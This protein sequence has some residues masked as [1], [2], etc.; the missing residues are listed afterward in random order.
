V[1][2]GL[3]NA[4]LEG[5]QRGT[6]TQAA[7]HGPQHAAVPSTP[8]SPARRGPQHASSRPACFL[9]P[10][11]DPDPLPSFRSGATLTPRGFSLPVFLSYSKVVRQAASAPGTAGLLPRLGRLFLSAGSES[12]VAS[13]LG[14]NRALTL[15]LLPRP[16]ACRRRV[17]LPHPHVTAHARLLP[18]HSGPFPTACTGALG[19]IPASG[20][21]LK[22]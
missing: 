11:Q 4:R 9:S 15:S 10:W 1:T 8:R 6:P 20:N 14:E 18:L 5:E 19:Q 17:T 21:A 22:C 13:E 2:G 16:A 3:R 12:P 7:R